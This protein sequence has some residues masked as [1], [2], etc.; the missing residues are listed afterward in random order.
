MAGASSALCKRGQH[1][2][3]V[4]KKEPYVTYNPRRAGVLLHSL[5]GHVR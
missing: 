3:A 5:K 4:T 2:A 1:P